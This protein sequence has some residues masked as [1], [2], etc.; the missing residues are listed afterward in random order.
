MPRPRL[1]V[2]TYRLHKPSG[3][4]VCTVYDA[5]G[6]RREVVLGRHG[7]ADSKAEYARLCAELRPG[8]VMPGVCASLLVKDVIAAYW[9]HAV[10]YY[11]HPD[12]TATGEAEAIR[13]ALRPLRK[14]YGPTLAAEFGPKALKALQQHMAGL[15]W[16]RKLVNARI[17]RV[18][19]MFKWA[20]GE[21][22]VPE[23]VYGGLRAVSGLQAGRSA[24]RETEDVLP[25]PV[26][27]YE[28]T[29][30]FL[31]FAARALVELMRFTGMRPGEACRVTL[32]EIDRSGDVWVYAPKKHKTAFRGK[33]RA[34]AFGPKAQAVLAAFLAAYER[35]DL[36]AGDP[37]APVFSPARERQRR[38]AERR[39]KRKSKVQPSQVSRKK[40]GKRRPGAVYRSHGLATA[41]RRAATKAGVTPWHPN[42]LRHL[43][44]TEV[45]ERHGLEA[46]Q[47]VLGHSRAD[48]TQLYAL[49]STTKA[50]AVAADM[51]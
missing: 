33:K 25:V 24:A 22:L 35:F 10:A 45:R 26:A 11:R 5:D 29:L 46:A 37:T 43:V 49:T 23:A 4:A 19:R 44:G 2:P 1:E 17:G 36:L 8:G 47:V 27:D 3:N 21:E 28:A 34:V 42:Q 31:P 30:P 15:G 48:I 18:V 51:G 16:S 7:S 38:D 9:D 50:A 6:T 20:V 40:A 12:G 32:A 39:A 14:L 41:V 13:Y